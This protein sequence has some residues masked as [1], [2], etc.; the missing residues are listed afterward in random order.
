MEALDFDRHYAETMLKFDHIFQT[1]GKQQAIKRPVRPGNNVETEKQ[2]EL[3]QTSYPSRRLI[4]HHIVPEDVARKASLPE[5]RVLELC[6]S[7]HR[8]LHNW[9]ARNVS[10]VHHESEAKRHRAMALD[11]VVKK[12]DSAYTRF[13]EYDFKRSNRM[14]YI[15]EPK[16]AIIGSLKPI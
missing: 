11:E 1:P 10:W 5:D 4:N 9:N 8:A 2:C 3:C 6:F 16:T 15:A 13:I 7:C 12:Y 14:T